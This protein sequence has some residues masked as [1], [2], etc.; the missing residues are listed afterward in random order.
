[1]LTLIGGEYMQEK[2]KKLNN[3]QIDTEF[4]EELSSEDHAI[5]K[6]QNA[7]FEM[8]SQAGNSDIEKE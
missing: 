8:Y 1:M 5:Q 4:S 2:P 7:L 6:V 3:K